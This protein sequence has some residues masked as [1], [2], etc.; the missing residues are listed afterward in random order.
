MGLPQANL[1]LFFLAGFVALWGVSVVFRGLSGSRDTASRRCPQCRTDMRGLAGRRCPECAFDAASE[2][3]LHR[4]R[5]DRR[6][7]A[8]GT[9]AAAVKQRTAF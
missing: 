3:D 4:R 1:V 7:V 8:V 9:L 6:V 2:R 5:P